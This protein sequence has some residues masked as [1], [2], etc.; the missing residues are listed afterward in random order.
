MGGWEGFSKDNK[1][2]LQVGWVGGKGFKAQAVGS[3]GMYIVQRLCL[4]EGGRKI[5][6]FGEENRP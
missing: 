6:L 5:G 1:Q 4:K 3:L 2:L